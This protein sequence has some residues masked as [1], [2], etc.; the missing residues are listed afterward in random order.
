MIYLDPREQ[1]RPQRGAE[2]LH[3]L[4]PRA[5][6]E[7]HAELGQRIGGMPAIFTLLL[8]Y[9][10]R[11]SPDMLRA[12]AGDRFPPRPLHLVPPL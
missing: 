1:R 2:H 9:E 7:F 8:D 4:G 3:A 11:L 10:A 12:T 5:I 6:A